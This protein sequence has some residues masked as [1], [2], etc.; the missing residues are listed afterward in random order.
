MVDA[1]LL[2]FANPALHV[3]KV[4]V[5]GAQTLTTEQVFQE[6]RVPNR[7][8]IFLMLRQPFA[9]R[10]AQDP[11]VDH[12][13]F[14]VRLPNLLVLTVSERRPRAILAA[15]GRF[16]L[17]DTQGVPYRELERPLPALPVVQ[18]AGAA[19]PDEVA[20][21]RPL[22]VLWLPDAY[23]LLSLVESRPTLA[24]TKIIVDQNGNLCLNRKDLQIRLGQPD[25]LPRKVVL[26][27]AALSAQGGAVAA[28]A[29]YID[30]SCLQQP[31]WM[32]RKGIG[33]RRQDREDTD[34]PE[35]RTN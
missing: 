35:S 7:T 2:L 16:W 14:S 29:A 15:S 8:N 25:S 32:P 27:E 24:G 17:L 19:L 31:V 10:L 23:R 22:R 18:A 20:L 1:A 26:A 3:T 34:G 28:R 30:V 5:D 13:R 4:R 9:R 21:G 11:V 12:A 33:D 6:A